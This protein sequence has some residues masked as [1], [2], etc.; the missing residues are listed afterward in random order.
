M[1]FTQFRQSILNNFPKLLTYAPMPRL[2]ILLSAGLTLLPGLH[3]QEAAVPTP[4]Q[5]TEINA[6][7][8]RHNGLIWSDGAL[9]SGSLVADGVFVTAA[10]LVFEESGTSVTPVPIGQISYYPRWHQT[11]T[12]EI[13]GAN[14]VP[15]KM[16]YWTS[17][18]ER[19]EN[20]DSGPGLNSPD[21]FNIDWAVGYFSADVSAPA[22]RE[23][24]EVNIDKAGDVSVLR[25][26]RDKLFVGYPAESQ[27][28]P[29]GNK[30]LMHATPAAD[31]FCW[32][33]GIEGLE[34]RDSGGLWIGIHDFQGVTSYSGA[35]GGPVYARDDLGNW[36]MSGILV[37]SS[38]GESVLVRAL[39]DNA[40]EWVEQAL[41]E[42]FGTAV[43]LQ[44]VDNLSVLSVTRQSV[45]IEWSDHS[46]AEAGYTV[47]RQDN[48]TWEKLADL[49]ADASAF[50]DA[51]VAP[52]Q[53][54]HYRVQPFAANGNRAPKS[55]H[56]GAHTRGNNATATLRLAQPWLKFSHEGESGWYLDGA[57]RLRSG[58]VRPNGHS[59][60]VLD[61]L[62]PGTLQFAWGVSSEDNPDY[63]NPD[64]PEQGLIY[65]ALQLYLNGEPVT[66]GEEPVFLSGT[67]GTQAESLV[68]PAG[69]HRVEWRYGKDPYTS[70]NEDAGFLQ[71][72]AWSPDVLNPYPVYGAY[73]FPGTPWHGS[74]WFG[75][76]YTTESG[77]RA[78]LELGW[79]YFT[80]TADGRLYGYSTL[81]LIGNFYTTPAM[82]PFLYL[83]D[84]ATWMYYYP[85]TGQ[86]GSKA[87]FWNGKT[88][89]YI[90]TP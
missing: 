77:W 32:W 71:S 30:G 20:D 74:E 67:V 68:L 55:E 38:G 86:Y 64:S 46:T 36:M 84:S 43:P 27:S 34:D 24:A 29:A 7:P 5:S 69:A 89:R 78:H 53:L 66:A 56:A 58:E 79:M 85:G 22:I 59:S 15:V 51:T 42:R 76:Y 62:G 82:F 31:Y 70:E 33:G 1:P 73:A 81:P 45:G 90:Q 19:V 11:I 54:Y 10:H 40:W 23:H 14:Y 9:G 49:P 47:F 16:L 61:I 21:T 37:G 44:R 88:N 87:W 2:S 13:V 18:S 39:D 75:V 28:V 72:L 17:Y 52:G 50:I 4:L 35:S 6:E 8:Y 12:N 3:A 57:N 25:E 48:G 65:D 41:F 80:G 83:L 26:D 60:L 63:A